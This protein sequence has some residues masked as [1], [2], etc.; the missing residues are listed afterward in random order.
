MSYESILIFDFD[1]VLCNSIHD[2]LF[3]ALQAYSDAVPGH[4]LPW[5]KGTERT[6][7]FQF[8]KENAGFFHQFT[9]LM[10]LGNFAQD[11][12]VFL[13]LLETDSVK[14]IHSQN[15]FN[16]FKKTLPEE[17]LRSYEEIFYRNRV[18]MQNENPDEWVQLLPCFEGMKESIPELA[19]RFLLAIA[20]S[21]DYQSVHLLL[22]HWDLAKYFSRENILDKD[23]AESKREHLVKFQEEHGIPYSAMHFIDDKL[24]HLF[25]VQDLGVQAYLA[26][27]GF[28]TVREHDLARKSGFHTLSL[29]DLPEFGI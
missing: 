4:K 14:S 15:D 10:P 11:Y 7:I 5:A 3:T 19:H 20:T 13:R 8:E 18:G 27:W 24:S 17:Q 25:A 21:K 26:L 6:R 23:F 1:G 29:E 28:N 22:N 16:T 12:F 9:D 2:S